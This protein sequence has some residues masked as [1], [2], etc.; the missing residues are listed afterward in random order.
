MSLPAELFAEPIQLKQLIFM[1]MT[2]GFWIVAIPAAARLPW[3][4]KVCVAGILFMAINPIDITLFSYTNYRGDIRGIEFGITD[5]FTSCLVI[6]MLTAPR[7]KRKRLHFA[8][9]M[10]YL[11][12]AYLA[13]CILSIFTAEVPQF[14][15]F[16]VTKLI[17]GYVTFWVAFNILRS[18]EDLRFFIWCCVGLTFYSFIQVLLDKYMRGVFPPRGSFP[19][20][21]SLSTF[22]NMINF[23]IFASLLQDGKKLFDRRTLIYWAATGAGTLTTAATLSRGGMATMV[24]GYFVIFVLTLALKQPK[25][26][27]KRKFKALGL[28]CC[29]AIPVLAFVLPPIIKRFQTAPKESGESR[30]TANL[31]SEAMGEENFLGIGLN[32]YSYAVNFMK[33]GENLGEL[34]RGI[35]HHIFWLHY[36]ELGIIGA[37]L[38]TLMTGGFMVYA[39]YFISQRKDS[40]AR[41]IAIGIFA[42]FTVSWMIGMLEW[43]WKQIQITVAYFWY[44][45]LLMSLGRQEQEQAQNKKMSLMQ[46]FYLWQAWQNQCAGASKR[47]TKK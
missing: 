31:A 3:V 11:M 21:N 27:I 37:V 30:D 17:R 7:W 16:G 5:W 46:K 36:A 24:F 39:L 6:T 25:Q 34:D 44:A 1:G 20:Q 2:I 13:Y 32:N 14:A 18:E 40:L 43:A 8:N 29:A 35:A 38:F 41:M 9:P 26:K 42:A 28:M 12:M 47:S 4:E 15:F 22:Q 19:H 33:Y 45:G 10:I 23:I